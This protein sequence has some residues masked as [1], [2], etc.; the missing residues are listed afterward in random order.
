MSSQTETSPA[1]T[2]TSVDQPQ[3]PM[4]TEDT[5]APK[6]STRSSVKEKKPRKPLSEARVQQLRQLAASAR[7]K[8]AEKRANRL[9]EQKAK[10]GAE[11][12]EEEEKE[13]K[14]PRLVRGGGEAA[15]RYLST[16]KQFNPDAEVVKSEP[17]NKKRKSETQS[18]RSDAKYHED[19][20]IDM[21]GAA[22]VGLG[23]VAA[24]GLAYVA[25]KNLNPTALKS[26]FVGHGSAIMGTDNQA[27]IPIQNILNPNPTRLPPMTVTVDSTGRMVAPSVGYY[28][29]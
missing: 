3:Q 13:E 26:G 7:A 1:A 10:R 8:K 6:K 5:N 28:A 27:A 19:N 18:S 24:A 22:K 11:E 16:L 15:G 20:D 12:G 23:L 25:G 14:G 17:K 21:A 2:P 9:K 29:S 4:V